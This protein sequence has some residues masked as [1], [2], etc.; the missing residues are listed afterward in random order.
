MDAKIDPKS[1]YLARPWLKYYDPGVPAE[2]DVP[3]LSLG[4]AFDAATERHAERTALEF[5]GR[6]MSFRDLRTETDRAAGGFAAL[7][8]GKGDRVALYLVNSP[9]FVIVYFAL[10]KLGCVVTPVSPVYTS[11]EVR[12]QLADSGARAI[13]CQDILYDNV[14]RSGARLD[15]IV[16]TA[17]DEYLPRFK[18]L[19]GRSPLGRLFPALGAGTVA[20]PADA[21]AI[22]LRDLIAGGKPVANAAIDPSRDLAALPYTGGTTGAP[23]GVMLT[24]GNLAAASAVGSATFA[25]Y[26]SEREV[27]IAFLPFFHIYGQVVIM[28]NG[29]LRGSTLVL[30]TTPHTEEILAAI[31]RHR[32]SV[33][34][35]VPTLYQYLSDHK[36]TD[37]VDW[38][39]LK[40]VLCGADTLHEQTVRNWERRTKT[41][42]VEGYGLSETCAI[43]HVNPTRR[44]K[45]GSFGVPVPGMWAAV[46]D[47]DGSDCRPVGESGELVLH[48]PNVMQG[49]WQSPADT[50]HAFLDLDG[51]RWLRT[52]DIVRMD[53]DGYFFFLDR[54]KDLIK[55]RGHS[56]FARDIEHVLYAHP[57]VKSAGVVGVPDPE[58]G[59]RIRALVVL[60]PDA[61]GK[62]S[63]DE[64]IAYCRERL[65]PYKVPHMVEFRGELPKTD[66][67][68]VSRRELREEHGA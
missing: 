16:V 22:R 53:E 64:I 12:H 19:L 49:Y 9:Q 25:H 68:K 34:Y 8:L 62:V 36:D 58:V 59:Q 1:A 21:A 41:P 48:G 46:V 57:K 54:R 33:F 42:I 37:K 63:E 47:P 5:Y 15:R 18:K 61:R 13:V 27:E 4:D 7:G 39:R 60:N 31:E 35:G 28:L 26:L 29:L 43:S 52:G 17:I 30:F 11:H 3:A 24:H 20:L 38:R 67:G 44:I 23:K 10:L 2:V 40:L 32:A 65:A 55:Y 56:V 45:A 50:A 51:R 14:V 66:V 6:S